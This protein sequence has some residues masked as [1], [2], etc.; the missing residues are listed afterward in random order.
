MDALIRWG[1]SIALS[2]FSAAIISLTIG[3][4]RVCKTV[5]ICG[6]AAVYIG[7]MMLIWGS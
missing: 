6:G 1:V 5:A 7:M 4:E 3:N 2:G